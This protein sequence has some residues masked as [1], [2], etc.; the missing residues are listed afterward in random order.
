[1]KVLFRVR[2]GPLHHPPHYPAGDT[3]W[4]K[5]KARTLRLADAPTAAA[6]APWSQSL[7]ELK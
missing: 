1:M 3:R 5:K 6:N 7:A 4:T 2:A